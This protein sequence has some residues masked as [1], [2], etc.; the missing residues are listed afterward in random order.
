M[1]RTSSSW[2]SKTRMQ[3][4]HSI[5][6]NLKLEKVKKIFLTKKKKEVKFT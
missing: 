6:H 3:A 5:S 2:P 1:H 4:P